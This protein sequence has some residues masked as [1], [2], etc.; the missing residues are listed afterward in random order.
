M[1]TNRTIDDVCTKSCTGQE[2]GGKVEKQEQVRKE[3]RDQSE[4]YAACLA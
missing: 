3:K 2:E 4:A 1:V